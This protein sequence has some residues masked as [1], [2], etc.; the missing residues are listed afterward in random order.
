[1]CCSVLQCVAVCCI[2]LQCVAVRGL[3]VLS[4]LRPCC[5]VLQCVAVCCSVLQC[6]AVY[7]SARI[8]CA[9]IG[10]SFRKFHKICNMARK[11]HMI[12][13]NIFSREY[14]P[15]R[16]HTCIP[17]LTYVQLHVCFN[18][19]DL[20]IHCVITAISHVFKPQAYFLHVFNGTL[21]ECINL[22]VHMYEFSKSL[23]F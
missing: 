2:V 3:C 19:C 20:H 11:M 12:E 5:R 22:K 7:C 10:T 18:F 16:L 14:A 21:N 4:S 1:M 17:I 13:L 9:F 23:D 15:S 6:V 8:A